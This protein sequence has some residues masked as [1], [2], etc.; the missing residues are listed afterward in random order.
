M[1]QHLNI[2]AAGLSTRPSGVTVLFSG[3]E[4]TLDAT[5]KSVFA[6]TDLDLDKLA[7]SIRFTGKPG[8]MLEVLAPNGLEA[9]RV[10]I[11]AR[12]APGPDGNASALSYRDLG[13][14]LMGRLLTA[15]T[16]DVVVVFDGA[17]DTPEA[18]AEFAAGLTLRHYKFDRYKTKT[19]PEDENG[20]PDALNV[21]LAVA[22][23]KATEKAMTETLAMAEGV[24]FAR[25][26]IN[27][28]PN[29]LGPVELSEQASE[30]AALGVEVEILTDVEMTELGMGAL[31]AVAQGSVRPARLAVLKWNGGKKN[32]APLAIV[33]KGVA[34]D[35]GGI[36]LKPGLNMEEMKGDMGGAAAVLGTMKA[37]AMRK[38]KA[39]VV[40]ICG[41]VENLPDGNAYRP[42]DIITSMSGQTIEIVNTDAEGRLVLADA[43]W[44]AQ[45]RFKPEA[46]IN[47]ATLTGAIGIALGNDHAGLFS[48]DDTLAG[49][50]T[51]AGLGS[52]EKFW[53]LPMG[54]AYDKLIDSRFA[55]MKNSGGRMAG[56]ITAAQFLKRFVADVPWAHLDIAG[57]AFGGAASDTNTS[58]GV[59]FGV[60]MLDKLVREY[61]EG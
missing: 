46:V 56:S 33:G 11:S 3:P 12:Q 10:W 21:T 61:F 38:A 31:L 41:F 32:R 28:P 49:N 58:W 5:A 45:D 44:Y 54:P 52:G 43:L 26:L 15:R 23:P 35:A 18:V 14:A 40:G 4:L 8:Q 2:S 48:N 1:S 36:S 37:L 27:L 57:T 22:D 16:G 47:L 51:E 39:N 59:G 13:G 17:S 60:A 55:D 53:R 29:V 34:F 19:K 25:D 20:E 50:I 9:E 6:E 42:G 24:L 30:L 7:A